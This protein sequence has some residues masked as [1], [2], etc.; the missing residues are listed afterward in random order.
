M[1]REAAWRSTNAPIAGVVPVLG[2]G[3]DPAIDHKEDHRPVASHNRVP[4]AMPPCPEV[5]RSPKCFSRSIEDSVLLETHHRVTR[6]SPRCYKMHALNSRQT[7]TSWE[8]RVPTL[9]PKRMSPSCTRGFPGSTLRPQSATRVNTR[10]K[11]SRLSSTR[12]RWPLQLPTGSTRAG[13]PPNPAC[14]QRGAS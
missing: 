2:N 9:R 10:A 11:N 13:A 14:S 8:A 7:F 1:F 5:T 12:D 4:S 3:L 6:Y